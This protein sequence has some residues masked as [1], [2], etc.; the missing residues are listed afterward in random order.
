MP[1]HDPQNDRELAT[2][3]RVKLERPSMF[4]VILHN[5]DYTT[6]EFVV[7]ILIR[8]FGHDENS[9]HAIMM[10]VHTKGMGVAGVYPRDVA[11]SKAA[12]VVAHAR[13][14]GMPLQCSVRRQAC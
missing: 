1:K 11:E 5:D 9:A 13:R 6:Q 10:H 14:Q 8:F 2:L 7:A 4:E 12:Q 3:D